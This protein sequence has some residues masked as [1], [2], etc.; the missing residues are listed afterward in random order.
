MSSNGL[1][2]RAN[3]QIPEEKPIGF[4]DILLH[5]TGGNTRIAER[6][7]CDLLAIQ[8]IT[9]RQVHLESLKGDFFI[10]LINPSNKTKEK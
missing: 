7:Y 4:M 9:H 10:S 8:R 5:L 6:L 3:S 2:N 1:E